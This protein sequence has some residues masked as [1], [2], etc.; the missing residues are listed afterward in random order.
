VTRTP[1]TP[2]TPAA[3]TRT[4]ERST[5]LGLLL[6]AVVVSAAAEVCVSVARTNQ[7][8]S[9]VFT[10]PVALLALGLLAHLA[11]RR[12]AP[13]ADPLLLPVTVLLCGIGL[14][15][16]ARIDASLKGGDYAPRQLI[17]MT[18]GVIGFVLVLI[19]VSDHRV[20]GRYTFT[21]AL[22]GIVL[23]LL[24]SVLPA[25]YSEINGAR[26]WI[27]FQGFSLQPSEIAKLLLIVFCA[28]YLVAKRDVMSILSRRVLGLP[29]PRGRDLA[30]LL[31]AWLAS[32]AVLTRE[33]DLGSSLLFFGV[34]LAM[35]YVATERIS[36]I[37]IGLAL[38]AVGATVAYQV[39]H[40]VRERVDIWLHPFA[41]GNIL[42]SSYQ[43]V[44]GLYGFG[45]GGLLGTGLGR[46][47]PEVVPFSRTDFIA[48]AVGEELGLVGLV[49]IILL[50]GVLVSRGIRA[51]VGAPDPFGKLLAGGLAA[52][53]ALQV[54]VVLGGVLRV[55]PLT[56]L[57]TPF[58]SY[59]G[60]S[61]LANFAL[62][63]LLLRVSDAGR[64]PPPV[65]EDVPTFD[66]GLAVE[67]ADQ[68]PTQVLSRAGRDR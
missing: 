28:G 27:R 39:F 7:L 31:I 21:A 53:L 42:D 40:H 58:L 56:G 50:Y 13:Y 60:S 20:L 24:P 10:H 16:V 57:T 8:R 38:F 41:K 63:A 46:G 1:A 25:R 33:K 23:L 5:E 51:A 14:A 66:P 43:L 9:G 6:L 37:A 54:F 62:I 48:S 30:P 52:S 4:S 12:T 55:I 3:V 18:I 49:A 67:L 59:G 47:H 45:A 29:V 32:V 36:W 61:L 34:F 35:V 22:A 65:L 44:Q 15:M 19:L 26:V 2:L 64:R 68:L 17:W 11:V